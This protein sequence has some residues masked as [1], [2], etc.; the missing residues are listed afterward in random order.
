MIEGTTMSAENEEIENV[1][2]HLL[3]TYL[4]GAFNKRDLSAMRRGFHE[5]FAI[6]SAEGNA[7]GRF[8]IGEWIGKLEQ[9][10][11][12]GYDAADEKNRWEHEFAYVDV[13]G[14]AAFVK[15]QLY[16]EGVHIYTDFISLLKFDDGWR[17][18]AK[19]YNQHNERKNW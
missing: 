7:L 6:F 2:T 14:T 11:A 13:T 19:I 10:L 8:P 12:D 15:L 4:D 17:I 16:N 3:E 1:K 9:S 18:S 5:D